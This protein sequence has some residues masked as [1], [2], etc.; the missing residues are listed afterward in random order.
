MLWFFG[1]GLLHTAVCVKDREFAY[2]GH[3][4]PGKSGV[5]WTQP[6]IEPPGAT[7]RCELRH[8]F[9]QL[10]VN[11][12]TSTIQDVAEKFPGT[13]YN[14]LTKNCNHFTSYLCE[15]LTGRAAPTWINRAAGIGLMLPC[16]I[17]QQWIVPPDCEIEDNDSDDEPADERSFMIQS[18]QATS[19]AKQNS[20]RHS[21]ASSEVSLVARHR[22]ESFRGGSGRD[23]EERILPPS[24]VLTS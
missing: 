20:V 4:Q 1:S 18:A 7:F 15:K 6:R 17:P 10:S 2:G 23:S 14:L 8:G 11:K 12:L 13:S 21:R 24:E 3:D 22:G 16:L 5:Y 9:S 19:S